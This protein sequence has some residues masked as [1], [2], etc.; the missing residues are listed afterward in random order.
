MLYGYKDGMEM[1]GVARASNRYQPW[2]V[3]KLETK[4][5]SGLGSR[6]GLT[7]LFFQQGCVEMI[8]VVRSSD[9]Y[10]PWPVAWTKT[11]TKFGSGSPVF[12]VKRGVL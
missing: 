4:T 2:S 3:E 8:G 9:R 5:K 11:E 1:T 7:W 12:V 10:Q 6:V